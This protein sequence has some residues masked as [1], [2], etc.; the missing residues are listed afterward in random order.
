MIVRILSLF[1]ILCFSV[2]S[3]AEQPSR[4]ISSITSLR[5]QSEP[6]TVLSNSKII[7]DYIHKLN[8]KNKPGVI[9]KDNNKVINKLKQNK[10][11]SPLVQAI[12]GAD[13][14]HKK[15][16]KSKKSNSGEHVVINLK[17]PENQPT[18]TNNTSRFVF[19]DITARNNST[20]Q[21]RPDL[22]RRIS[23]VEKLRQAAARR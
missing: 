11:I 9:N 13:S 5:S 8:T 2:P 17:L 4:N 19:S 14:W 20:A 21:Q 18:K 6:I 10:K 7:R 1:I 23:A 22:L 12:N 16:D 15:T 3:M